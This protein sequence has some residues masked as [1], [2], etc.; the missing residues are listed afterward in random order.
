MCIYFVGSKCETNINECMPNPCNTIGTE[1][2]APPMNYNCTDKVNDYQCTCKQG[3]EGKNCSVRHQE[4]FL[5]M[6]DATLP[7]P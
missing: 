6:L 2:V 4:L 7:F 1:M 3:Y 5:F